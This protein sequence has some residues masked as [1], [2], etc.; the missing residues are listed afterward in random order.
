VATDRAGGRALDNQDDWVRR[1]IAHAFAQRVQVLP[2]LVD[3]TAPLDPDDLPA[4]IAQLARCQYLRMSYRAA[5]TDTQRV[6]DELVKLVPGLGAPAAR[7]RT[8]R[9]LL[10]GVGALLLV[11]L[12][13]LGA[14]T[15]FGRH[16]RS[17]P[18]A[19]PVQRTGAGAT[20]LPGS[21][22]AS[23]AWLNVRPEVGGP[24][25]PFELKG[26][27]FP[28]RQEIAVH[29]TLGNWSLS[30]GPLRTDELGDLYASVDPRVVTGAAGGLPPGVHVI[31]TSWNDERRYHASARYTVRA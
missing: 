24:T 15:W 18:G 12:L 10:G 11:V 29:I 27:G 8:R 13:T 26:G 23:P 7:R 20:A 19:G 30:L 25:D 17:A 1:E 22:R 6:G 31:A 5:A 4:D 28:P 16:D 3:N 9:R 21:S 14:A 2:I